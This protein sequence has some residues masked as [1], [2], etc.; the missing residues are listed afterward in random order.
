MIIT[1]ILVFLLCLAIL[2]VFK[3]T[4]ALYSAMRAS[5][6]LETT[7]KRVFIL[8]VS[9]AYILTIIFTGLAI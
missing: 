4:Y 3:E 7:N 9:I 6:K 8:G 2:D 1:K 5:V